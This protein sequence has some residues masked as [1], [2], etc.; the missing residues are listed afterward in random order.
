MLLQNVPERLT[1][2]EQLHFPAL[3]RDLP[4]AEL[5]SSRRGLR[6]RRREVRL[7]R[8]R[9]AVYEIKDAVAGGIDVANAVKLPRS[10]SREKF[11]K[12]P[13]AISSPVR[14]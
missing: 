13:L 12:R 6:A 5:Q 9:I 10:A 2:A 1:L 8:L 11:G 7:H 3:E 14:S 4:F